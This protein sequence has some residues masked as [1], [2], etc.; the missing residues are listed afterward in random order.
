VTV[1][2][3]SAAYAA[4][5][6]GA[7]ATL[8]IGGAGTLTLGTTLSV[9]AGTLA[10]SN[11]GSIA[12]QTLTIGGAGAL[13][14]TGTSTV[15]A[16]FSDAGSITLGS[17]SLLQLQGGGAFDGAV[18]GAG[19]VSFDGGTYTATLPSLAETTNLLVELGTL[20]FAGGGGV[21]NETIALAG[22]T[23]DLDTTTAST[24]TAPLTI[25][26]GALFDVSGGATLMGAVSL[27]T[28]AVLSAGSVT[29]DGP[30]SVSGSAAIVGNLTVNGELIFGLSAGYDG[31][32]EIGSGTLIT[33]GTTIIN[34]VSTNS[35]NLNLM[36]AATWMNNGTV[37]DRG[38]MDTQG[39]IFNQS[40]ASFYLFDDAAQILPGS[41]AT[42]TFTN[43]GTLAKTSGIGTSTVQSMVDSTGL[44]YVIAGELDLAGGGTLGGT[45]G[46]AGT[47]ALGGD[48]DT[49]L[50]VIGAAGNPPI[51]VTGTL[52]I[53]GASGTLT[54]ALTWGNNA[55]LDVAA[56][57]NVT[58]QSTGIVDDG[59][60][61]FGGPGRV[62]TKGT[63][64]T[65]AL[66]LVSGIH[67]V[68]T[69]VAFTDGI[70]TDDATGATISIVN[71]AGATLDMVQGS[72]VS[73]VGTVKGL[74]G[75]LTNQG[76]LVVG[77]AGATTY[78]DVTLDSSGVLD[79]NGGE[80][81]LM[82]GG[83]LTGAVNST[84]LINFYAGNFYAS[85]TELSSLGD[86]L[87]DTSATLHPTASGTITATTSLNGTL[88]VASD[89]A[90]TLAETEGAFVGKITLD[91]GSSVLAQSA[92][93]IGGAGE[94]EDDRLVVLGRG[95]L[96]TLGTTTVNPASPSALLLG[97]GATWVNSG[98]VNTTGDIALNESAGDSATII[99]TSSGLIMLGGINS[100]AQNASGTDLFSNFGTID[101][102]LISSIG[103]ATDNTGLISSTGITLSFLGALTNTGTID[104]MKG[105]IS[106]NQAVMGNGT[107]QVGDG[108]TLHLQAGA[109]SGQ[110]VDFMATAATLSL[111]NPL[112]FLGS[113]AGF[114]AGDSIE[115]VGVNATGLSYSGDTLTAMVGTATVA[116]L[117]FA[118]SY[119]TDNF[120]FFTDKSGTFISF[121]S[122]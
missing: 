113:L 121:Q 24:L 72:G 89:M 55:V 20:A 94:H 98:T 103:I 36:A 43:A 97:D 52:E 73:E 78:L 22:G 120:S 23:F 40:G 86:I 39:T 50:G 2:T 80:V 83:T 93:S 58:V 92:I 34:E 105:T 91:A 122:S 10:L 17:G 56:A 87:V 114:G 53:S 25:S 84:A 102:L 64:S 18:S 31:A 29:I 57:V 119:S 65:I 82:H 21:L 9:L 75:T 109:Q 107:L 6:T 110:I 106:I 4:T 96:A 3:F 46:G 51:V 100:I 49:T 88:L 62:T 60:L 12:A 71:A 11:G 41:E 77:G 7:G 59:T 15:T 26:D 74:T 32:G 70:S 117:Q 38:A 13:L 67:W 66:S 54:N 81:V 95:T 14:T 79:A 90:I 47:L 33:N 27:D 116:S 45:L 69:G 63:L 108:G 48:F 115:L 99:N 104:A 8:A 1:D 5:L 76:T 68:N 111:N 28:N 85:P 19:T 30:I 35:A 44:I 112:D 118:G 101:N 16:V 37:Y 61:G 42:G